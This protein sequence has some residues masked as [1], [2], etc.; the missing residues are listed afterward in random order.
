MKNVVLLTLVLLLLSISMSMLGTR[1]VITVNGSTTYDVS[2]SQS[3]QEAINSAQPGDTIF[4]HSGTY[5][6]HVVVSKSISLIGENRGTT[7]VDGTKA[8]YV[9]EVKA[10]NVTISGFTIQNG[11]RGICIWNY[12]SVNVTDNRVAHNQYGIWLHTSNYSIIIGNVITSNNRTGVY[13]R[14]NNGTIILHNTISDNAYD[15]VFMIN[16]TYSIVRENTIT[17]NNQSGISLSDSSG[18]II[19]KNTISNN[20]DGIYS[21]YSNG[22]IISGNHIEANDESGIFLDV[23]FNNSIS[24]NSL[25]SNG[26]GIYPNGCG[27]YLLESL[28]NTIYHNDFVNNPQ[29]VYDDSW[30]SPDVSPSVNTWDDGYPSGGNYWRDYTDVDLYSGPY[31]NETGSDGIWDHSYVIDGNNQD[32]YPLMNPWVVPPPLDTTPPTLSILSPEN[33]TYSVKDVP[34]TYTVSES[35]SWIGYSLDN[36]ANLTITGNTTLSALS[37]GSHSL[38]LYAKDIAGNT[39]A[40]ELICFSI[41]T[42][43]AEPFPLWNAGVVA[44]VLIGTAVAAIFLWRRRK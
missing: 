37:G 23:A 7:I 29:H 14:E 19:I 25:K 43:Q 17:S 6:E 1:L 39:G 2:P 27:I 4:V 18:N 13:W 30:Y 34:L 8:G 41:K 33:K 16:A 21:F 11:E 26:Y 36:M 3:I 28:N 20:F 12:D 32:N 31:Q 9:I 10:D 40:S 35:T 5:Y 22:N 15:G 44:V 38:I 42:K 24:G